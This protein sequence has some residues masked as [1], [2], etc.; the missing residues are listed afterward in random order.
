MVGSILFTIMRLR[1]SWPWSERVAPRAVIRW[2]CNDTPFGG[3]CAHL[4]FDC[5][6]SRCQQK[7]QPRSPTDHL[8]HSRLQ[9]RAIIDFLELQRL[10]QQ[11]LLERALYR[12]LDI[13]AHGCQPEGVRICPNY[14]RLLLAIFPWKVQI[15]R[16]IAPGAFIGYFLGLPE[17]VEQFEGYPGMIAEDAVLHNHV[18]VRLEE[19]RLPI[20]FEDG[21]LAVVLEQL[22]QARV[23]LDLCPSPAVDDRAIAGGDAALGADG[24]ARVDFAAVEHHVQGLIGGKP[25][26]GDTCG[27]G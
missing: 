21:G 16:F 19:P 2:K 5:R 6:I 13:S 14:G 20:E 7:P 3:Q 27:P 10:G 26:M 12:A 8:C 24:R 9:C 4:G 17:G 23:A 1:S 11:S 18:V 15:C 22:P 25:V